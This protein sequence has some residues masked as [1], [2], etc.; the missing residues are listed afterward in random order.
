MKRC[1]IPVGAAVLLFAASGLTPALADEAPASKW[2]GSADVVNDYLFRGISQTNRKP[3]VQAGLE[4]DHASGWYIGGWGSNVSWLSDASTSAQPISSS[5]EIDLYG[6]YRGSFSADW[7]PRFV[8]SSLVSVVI[9]G[10]AA[11]TST[12]DVVAPTASSTLTFKTWLAAR[13]RPARS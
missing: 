2:V 12:T 11:F 10:P 8:E 3:A 13:F 1:W 4:F 6:G 9:V 7:L 5:L